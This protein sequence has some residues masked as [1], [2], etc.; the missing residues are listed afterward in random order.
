ML[1]F[2]GLLTFLPLQTSPAASFHPLGFPPQKEAPDEPAS[3]SKQPKARLAEG[4]PM[5]VYELPD[6]HGKRH[7][8]RTDTRWIIVSF[9]K[10]TGILARRWLREKP[11]G[12][13]RHAHIDFIAEISRIPEKL[14]NRRVL[15]KIRDYPRQV[16]LADGGD[17]L[18]RIPQKRGALTV[19]KLSA[20]GKV[21]QV[22]F[23]PS[24]QALEALIEHGE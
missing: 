23:P 3:S 7:T 1:A 21:E 9:E 24:K 13:L 17:V 12:Y 8:Y 11:E 6:Q 22:A 15:P 10:R 5:F 19:I 2:I 20:S 18:E 16:L 4:S 14:A